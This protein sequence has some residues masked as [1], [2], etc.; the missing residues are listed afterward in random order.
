[1][2]EIELSGIDY[3]VAEAETCLH[4]KNRKL[5]D[6]WSASR[7]PDGVGD[8]AKLAPASLLPLLG[9]I[10]VAQPVEG[11]RDFRFRLVGTVNEERLGF[12]A[13][14]RLLTECYG[15]KMAKELIE[16]HNRV[17]AEKRPVI[18]RGRFLGVGLEHAL[19][20]ALLTPVRTSGGDMQ[21]FAGM[22]DMGEN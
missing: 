5:L 17:L 7:A 10:S 6:L 22:Y 21:V 1:M 14:G 15:P 16:L 4:P 11:G 2:N 19:F 9:G 12:A 3:Q 18:L 20:E 8:R 13:T